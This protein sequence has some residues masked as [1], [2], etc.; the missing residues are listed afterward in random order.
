MCTLT[1]SFPLIN[2]YI[3]APYNSFVYI[4]EN[5]LIFTGKEHLKETIIDNLNSQKM[6]LRGGKYFIKWS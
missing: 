1:L 6:E 5:E 4:N 3:F 2:E